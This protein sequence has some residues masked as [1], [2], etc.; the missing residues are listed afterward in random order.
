MTAD[1]ATTARRAAMAEAIRERMADLFRRKAMAEACI[2]CHEQ[3]GTWEVHLKWSGGLVGTPPKPIAD[4][5]VGKIC[6]E[7]KKEGLAEAA[8][9][10]AQKQRK[11]ST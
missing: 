11:E 8:D 1:D 6:D 10:A 4:V 3:P 2:A 7:C 5:M 9:V